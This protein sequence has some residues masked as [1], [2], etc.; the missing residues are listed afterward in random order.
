MNEKKLEKGEEE[1][2]AGEEGE[3]QKGEERGEGNN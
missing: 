1:T 2:D 3:K